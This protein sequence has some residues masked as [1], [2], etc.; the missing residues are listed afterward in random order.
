M[1]RK[2]DIWMPWYLGDYFA[3][4]SHLSTEQHGAYLLLLAHYWR[5]G[6]L[7]DDDL[8]LSRITK[9]S[10]KSWR[11]HAP[12]VRAFFT[13]GADGLL[14]NKRSDLE[15]KRWNEKKL[16]AVEKAEKAAEARWGNDA[17]S[18]ATST[19]TDDAPSN[20]PSNHQALLEPCPSPLPL[21]KNKK[22][23]DPDG[24]FL[25]GSETSKDKKRSGQSDEDVEKVRQAYPLKKAPGAAR[26]AIT[27]AMTRLGARGESDPAGFLIA[28]IAEWKASRARD[29]AAGRF[30]PNYPYPATW[31]NDERYDEES[32][33]PAKNCPLP[34]GK[35]GTAAELEEQTG[36]QVIRG[37]V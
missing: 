2:T 18:N 6:S 33:Q 30:V 29:E 14:H 27:K 24:F 1:S 37:A 7:R 9:L 12:V 11:R 23:T 32:L 25:C 26:K 22:T 4:T 3:D 17:P 19:P 13:V 28:R 34:N 16:K 8:S 21:P 36:W 35:L 5:T 15:L 31:M 10:L 20:A